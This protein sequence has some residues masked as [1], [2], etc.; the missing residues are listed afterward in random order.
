MRSRKF[1]SPLSCRCAMGVCKRGCADA[2]VEFLS[3]RY[4]M[5]ICKRLE[6]E[7]AGIYVATFLS[8]CY[9][10][11]QAEWKY[12]STVSW[13]TWLNYIVASVEAT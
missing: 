3:A 12:S 2:W 8:L 4:S 11:L 5:G 6:S 1:T 7:V 10:G 13:W 9:G